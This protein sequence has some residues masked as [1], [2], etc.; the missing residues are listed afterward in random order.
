MSPRRPWL[1]YRLRIDRIR[2]TTAVLAAGLVPAML[3]ASAALPAAAEASTNTLATYGTLAPGQDIVSPDGHYEL[4]MQDDGNL[5]E[6]LSGGRALW[7]SGTAGDR[8]AHAVMQANG[9]LVLYDPTGAAVWSSNS[10]GTGCPVLVI[11]NDGNVVVS[12]PPAVWATHTVQYLMEPGDVLRPGWS[13]YS[14]SEQFQLLM[15]SDGNLVLYDGAGKALWASGTVGH[16]GAH[17]VMQTDGNLV[18]Y[19][20]AGHALWASR[21]PQQPGAFLYMQSDGNL[22]IYKGSA[23]LWSTA[24]NGKGSGGSRAPAVPPP[25]KCAPPA[26]PPPPVVTTPV[27]TPLPAPVAPHALAVRLRISW[28]WNHSVT[29]LNRVRIGRFPGLAQIF[30]QCRGRGCPGKR[31]I[32]ARG[33]R[34]VMR[35]LR[36]LRGKQYR[37]GDRLLIIIK[38]PGYLPERALVKIRDGRLPKL[39]PVPTQ[40]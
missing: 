28:T 9:N 8:G 5:V 27:S 16:P 37:A 10:R 17:A 20:S 19:D 23:A 2:R 3:A 14:P 4:L 12:S 34:H 22:V 35:L 1:P 36:A 24:T 39:I 18:V 26:P 11:Q 31:D 38:A 33:A 15:Q 13:I 6:Y 30:V 21:T 29:R 32:S 25:A 7:A 40:G